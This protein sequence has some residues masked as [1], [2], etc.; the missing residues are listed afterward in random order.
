MCS[1]WNTV[2]TIFFLF[3]TA[4]ICNAALKNQTAEGRYWGAQQWNPQQGWIAPQGWL[5]PQGWTQPQTGI[6]SQNWVAPPGGMPLPGWVPSP[7]QPPQSPFM[8]TLFD[9]RNVC[10]LDASI[11]V[12]LDN[13]ESIVQPGLDVNAQSQ[14]PY[15]GAD[16]SSN[17]EDVHGFVINSTRLLAGQ[18]PDIT[19]PPVRLKRQEPQPPLTL[20]PL[21]PVSCVCCGPRRFFTNWSASAPHL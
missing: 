3:I 5:S 17:A 14:P 21:P 15:Y 2:I 4:K 8:W 18:F 9:D 12:V 1:I 13:D 6:P 16:L 19:L 10:T 20:P 7:V 11:L